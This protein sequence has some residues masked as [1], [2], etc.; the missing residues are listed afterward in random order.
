MSLKGS[1]ESSPSTPVTA[2]P[3]FLSAVTSALQTMGTPKGLRAER[4][5]SDRASPRAPQGHVRARIDAAQ[6]AADAGLELKPESLEPL[7][8]RV[9]LIAER[10]HQR[11]AG[12]APRDFEGLPQVLL[13]TVVNAERN[14]PAG[15]RGVEEA[16]GAAG[17]AAGLAG[18]LGG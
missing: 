15:V 3:D 9:R 2:S 6:Y 12:L 13:G 10:A 7:E 5:R 8:R 17:E 18:L 1:P 16:V 4:A 11:L 14:L